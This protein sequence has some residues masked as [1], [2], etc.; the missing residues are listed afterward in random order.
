MES[1]GIAAAGNDPLEVFVYSKTAQGADLQAAMKTMASAG[2]V[3]VAKARETILKTGGSLDP[4]DTSAFHVI[5]ESAAELLA[6]DRFRLE[7]VIGNKLPEGLEIHYFD[8]TGEAYDAANCELERG[9]VMCVPGEGVVGLSW[10]WPIAVTEAAGELHLIE[11]GKQEAV[12]EDAG[13]S[14]ESIQV[15][16]ALAA[17]YGMGHAEWVKVMQGEAPDKAKSHGLGV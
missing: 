7:S 4:A 1:Q 16:L 17:D 10:D 8:S 6:F 9:S 3:E 14:P 15:A 5:A 13:F 11:N 2:P 12:L